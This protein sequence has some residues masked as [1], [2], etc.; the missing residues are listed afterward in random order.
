MMRLL[1]GD[2]ADD[3]G[4]CERIGEITELEFA[5]E[6]AMLVELPA[7]PE[8]GQKLARTVF[9]ERR[10]AAAAGNAL[11]IRETHSYISVLM[12]YRISLRE[13]LVP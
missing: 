3:V 6:M 10:H 12:V 5:R 2:P 11:F 9:G 7:V 1:F 4:E 8:L 13:A